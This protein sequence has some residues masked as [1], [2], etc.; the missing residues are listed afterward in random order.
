MI[1]IC[2]VAGLLASVLLYRKDKSLAEVK[3]WVVALM[4][5]FRFLVV[6]FLSFLLLAPLVRTLFKET[7]KPLIIIV[8]DGSSSVPGNADSTTFVPGY[9]DK[10]DNLTTTLSKAF[11]V[12]SFTT[13]DH[14]REGLDLNFSDKQTDLSAV[15]SELKARFAGRNTGAVILA[16]DGLYNTGSNPLYTYEQLHV[17]V[18]T[19]AMGDTTV[20]KDILIANL[21]YNRTT[22]KGNIFPVEITLDARQCAGQTVTLSVF[23]GTEKIYSAPVAIRSQRFNTLIPVYLEANS[24]G[25]QRYTVSVS[26]L[27]GEINSANNEAGFYIDVTD[28]RQKILLLANSPHPDLA[29]ISDILERSKSYDIQTDL[30]SNFKDDIT[31]YNL[32][33]LYQLPGSNGT[34]QQLI[35][36]CKKVG[37]PIWYILGA[38]TSVTAFNSLQ[39]GIT[40]S[41]NRGNTGEMQATPS[42]DFSLFG[43]SE[44]D[45]QTISQFPPLISP[46]GTYVAQPDVSTLLYQRIGQVRTTM[47]LL[48]YMNG[49]NYKTAFLCG[50][51]IWKWGLSEYE[52]SGNKNASSGIVLKTVQFLTSGKKT[53]PFRV[54]MKND[55]PE[56]EQV[57]ADAELYNETGELVNEPEAS[58]VFQN[59][60]GRKFNYVFARDNKAYTLNAGFLPQGKYSFTASVLLGNKSL[61]ESGIFTI[62][63]VLAEQSETVADHQLLQTLSIKTGGQMFNSDQIA[64]LADSLISRNDIRPVVYV[65]KKLDDLINLK[66]ICFVLAGFLTI[67]WIMRKRSGTY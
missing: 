7:E 33:I 15:V 42:T 4:S 9:R 65:R 56:N 25:V 30:I 21:R 57:V 32:A 64:T 3:G 13:G 34:A 8:Q 41:D 66:W 10:I 28:S 48:S 11:E 59:D 1:I 26:K 52:S 27:D 17:P 29:D 36:T 39:S 6:F 22:F 67:E 60:D 63:P 37:V 38:Q 54:Y 18:Y 58:I 14:V 19:I 47:P 55:Y 20:R 49:A 31:K 5:I 12:R 35:E 40:I 23:K 50:E 61:S 62:S 44:S 24:A 45:L 16:S 2:L 43:V 53:T 46:F 51:G